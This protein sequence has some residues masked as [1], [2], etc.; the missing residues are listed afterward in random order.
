MPNPILI[1]V[2]AH[3]VQAVADLI[4]NDGDATAAPSVPAPELVNGWTETTLRR[5]F[6]QSSDKMKAF[7]LYLAKHADSEVDTDTVA[8]A[9]GFPDWNSIAGMLG[10]AARRARNHYGR[11]HGPWTRRWRADGRARLTMPAAAATVILDEAGE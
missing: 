3:L 9:I 2:P 11:E 1:A 8:N 4:A 5:H 10:A 7:L 6:E